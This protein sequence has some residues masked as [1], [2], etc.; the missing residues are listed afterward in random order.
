M[1]RA[2]RKDIFKPP[3]V[4]QK[5]CAQTFFESPK[6]ERSLRKD[7]QTPPSFAIALAAILNERDKD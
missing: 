1:K 3:K 5:L 4:E 6:V 7:F 2:L